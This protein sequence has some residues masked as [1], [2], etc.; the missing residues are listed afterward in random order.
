MDD[1]PHDPDLLTDD[2]D[3]ENTD[4]R[5]QGKDP[6]P[7]WNDV[8]GVTAR[9]VTATG[10]TARGVTAR[11]VTARGVAAMGVTATGVAAMGVTATGVTA[12]GV[13]RDT[14]ESGEVGYHDI[15]WAEDADLHEDDGSH[16]GTKRPR[17]RPQ[18]DDGPYKRTRPVNRGTPEMVRV[19]IVGKM[20]DV[21]K[22]FND[23]SIKFTV[24]PDVVP[25]PNICGNVAVD[26][27]V[28]WRLYSRCRETGDDLKI[29][30][31]LVFGQYIT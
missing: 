9:G 24:V 29:T 11:G 20:E 7:A 17:S 16:H 22:V 1:R 27:K 30:M 3:G 4:D 2:Y 14:V 10:V 5:P 15:K 26:T 31:Q 12:R 21:F 18:M 23:E 25:L 6:I 28:A 8:M 13:S 19:T